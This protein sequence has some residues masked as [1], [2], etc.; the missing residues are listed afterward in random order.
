MD[1]KEIAKRNQ[2]LK[3]S[4]GS[5]LFGT[6][7]PDSD[8]DLLGIFMP[9]DEIVYGFQ[10]CEEVDLSHVAKNDTGRNTE[11]A[12]DFKI[13]E[14]RKFVRLATQNNP[15]IIHALFVNEPNIH[16]INEFGANLLSR[17]SMFIHKGAHNRFVKYADAQ[18][19]KMEIKPQNYKALEDGVELLGQMEDHLVMADACLRFGVYPFKDSGKGKHIQCGDLHFERGV[20]IK[21][22]RKMIKERL[23][24]ATSRQVLFTKFGYDVKFASNLIQLLLEGEELMLTGEIGFPLAYAQDVL[25]IKE[26]KHS[27]S[28]I[29][30]WADDLVERARQACEKSELPA[31]PPA[32]EIETFVIDEV[33]GFLAQEN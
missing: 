23:S 19:H 32:E 21:K 14:Y 30:E 10:R 18:R 5:N 29:I 25:D 31:E 12:I 26:G 2:I 4:V 6:N 17:K 22:A 28:Q 8:L 27:V 9:S 3:I 15:N 33:K 24:K 16:F 11:N 13:H 1:F 20:F 7:T